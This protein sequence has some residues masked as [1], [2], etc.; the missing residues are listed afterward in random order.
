M[1]AGTRVEIV[2]FDGFDELDAVGPL[3]VLRAAQLA[4]AAIETR[5]V[6][7]APCESVRGGH[8]LTVAV[9]GVLSA[10]ADWI[11]V[12]GGAWTNPDIP[13]CGHEIRRGVLPRRLAGLRQAG[14]G[15]AA[16]CT[17]TM[18]LAAAGITRGRRAI[19]HHVAIDALAANVIRLYVLQAKA[20]AVSASVKM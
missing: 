18:L 1:S 15:M 16:I 6:A 19:T 13:G 10:E 2:V 4:G 17:G 8:G 14:L 7:A 20:N 11:I 5:W 3:E 9:D 12:P